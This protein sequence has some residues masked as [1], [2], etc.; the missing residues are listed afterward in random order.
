MVP[1]TAGAGAATPLRAGTEDD[2]GRAGA[3]AP[4]DGRSRPQAGRTFGASRTEQHS[5]DE[6]ER[7][8]KLLTRWLP[9]AAGVLVL[10]AAGAAAVN[11]LDDSDDTAVTAEEAAAGDVAAAVAPRALL[12]TGTEYTTGDPEVF[13]QQVRELVVVAGAGTED[14][15][16][17]AGSALGNVADEGATAERDPAT[18]SAPA[19]V[20]PESA[21]AAVADNPLAEATALQE[22]IQAVTDGTDDSATAVDLALVD[23]VESTVVVVPD[24]AGTD[25]FVYVVGPDCTGIDSQFQFFTVTP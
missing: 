16:A 2:D 18:L 22:C 9:V 4:D 15:S 23:G 17:A 8:R 6:G 1:P 10:G 13:S 24:P 21:R 19:A 20:A 12:A 5:D 7:R 3:S 25:L 11:V 14:S